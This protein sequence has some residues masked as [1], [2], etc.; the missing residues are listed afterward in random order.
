MF[1]TALTLT[2]FVIKQIALR[3]VPRVSVRIKQ[4]AINLLHVYPKLSVYGF[5]EKLKYS[6][7]IY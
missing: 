3:P 4:Y 2:L 6:L 7:N 5:A 1:I